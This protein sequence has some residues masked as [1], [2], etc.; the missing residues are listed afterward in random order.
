MMMRSEGDN[1]LATIYFKSSSIAL[2]PH[3]WGVISKIKPRG[4]GEGIVK[5][6]KFDPAELWWE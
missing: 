1:A 3:Y 4:A 5:F 2:G 6:V